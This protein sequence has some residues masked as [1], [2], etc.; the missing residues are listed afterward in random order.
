MF[1]RFPSGG[2]GVHNRRGKVG[3]RAG[4][5]EQAFY[6]LAQDKFGGKRFVGT[7]GQFFK[8]VGIGKMPQ[9]VKQ[10][11]AQK[12]TDPAGAKPVIGSPFRQIE[13]KPP[14]QMVHPD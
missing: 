13:Q 9:I 4:R 2:F 6:R 12:R 3:I 1:S 8:R 14:G 5:P 7:Q 11:R 10:G